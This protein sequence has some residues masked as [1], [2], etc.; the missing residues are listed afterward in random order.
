MKRKLG[1][2]GTLAFAGYIA[3]AG[4]KSNP[5]NSNYESK[6]ESTNG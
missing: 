2:L 4:C 5:M 6:N 3:L 1:I